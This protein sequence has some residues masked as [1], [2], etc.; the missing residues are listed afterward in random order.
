MS[1]IALGEPIPV[2]TIATLA[3]EAPPA[4][5]APDTPAGNAGSGLA[6]TAWR[7]ALMPMLIWAYSV[8]ACWKSWERASRL[9]WPTR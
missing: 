6:E 5:P 8:E 7:L 1:K 9:D 4:R 2:G 3:D